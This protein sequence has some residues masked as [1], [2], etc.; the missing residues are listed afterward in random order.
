M[1][2][3]ES[4]MSA[5]SSRNRC[6][7]VFMGSFKFNVSVSKA[8]APLKPTFQLITCHLPQ[9]RDMWLAIVVYHFPQ[10]RCAH[11]SAIRDG[12]VANCS[13]GKPSIC[14]PLRECVGTETAG[15]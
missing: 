8:V 2:F 4:Y 3:S 13:E 14:H 9:L 6:F 1:R 10:V 5:S 15:D 11:S 12:N 7:S